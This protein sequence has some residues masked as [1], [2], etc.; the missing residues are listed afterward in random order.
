MNRSVWGLLS[1]VSIVGISLSIGLATRADQQRVTV[2]GTSSLSLQLVSRGWDGTVADGDS[3]N[4]EISADGRFLT[5]ASL[6]TNLTPGDTNQQQ[7]IF[8]YARETEQLMN[9]T[10][11][12]NGASAEPA[13]SA[14][15][16][17]VVF[18]SLATNLV[19][20]D[21]NNVQDVFL[22]DRALDM[23]EL[24]SVATSGATANGPSFYPAVS[25]DGRYVAF[26]SLA[27]N[28]VI[29]DTN[30]FLDIYVRD[31]ELGVT[32]LV[33]LGYDGAP[34]NGGSYYPALSDDGRYVVFY[35]DAGNLVV[36]D[37]PY[38]DVFVYDRQMG[39]MTQVS[40]RAGGGAANG[41]SYLPD[42]AG[43]GRFIAFTSEASNLVVGDMNGSY[44]VFLF[45][46]QTAETT[47]LSQTTTGAPGNGDS[48]VPY[49]SANGRY[50]TYFS[51]ANNLAV[52]DNNGQADAFWL[53]RENGTLWLLSQTDVGAAGNGETTF[54]V[55][56]ADGQTAVFESA[57]TDLTAEATNGQ[58]NI[59][60]AVFELAIAPPPPLLLPVVLFN[61]PPTYVISGQVRDG[62]GR[63]LP[64]VTL[65][66]TDGRITMTDG[67]GRYEFSQL[68]AGVY[69]LTPTKTGYVFTPME[70]VV[71]VPPDTANV[72]FTGNLSAT[73]TAT[74][75][76]TP[77]VTPTDTPPPS[78]TPT[79]TTPPPCNELLVNG[80]FETT[81]GWEIGNTAYPAAYDTAVVRSGSRAMR[82]GII[83]PAHNVQTYSSTSQWV[84]IPANASSATLSFWWYPVSGES[85]WVAP[86][87]WA[88]PPI[89]DE[90]LAD[91]AQFV[92]VYEQNNTQHTLL[93]Q[94]RNDQTWLPSQ[95]DLMPFAGQTIR[96]YFGVF[97]NGY[98]GVT[99]MYV[100]DVSLQVCRP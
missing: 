37:G 58:R 52:N 94:R 31:R 43:D 61:Y 86:Q 23:M 3:Q 53:D 2:A 79:A 11:G 74:P 57:A 66:T 55:V 100:D 93:F 15:G 1:L 78:P 28:L 83:N 21:T 84:T 65:T 64:D 7:D 38:S 41:S 87:N 5:F 72:D 9:V 18:E 30:L 14:D 4:S 34:S 12:A 92:I 99:G 69:Q 13:L 60:L 68:L 85:F 19:A 59:F 95:F 49:L 91:D 62:D 90:P 46:Q 39:A 70:R 32:E 48:L 40:T 73:A 20:E 33:T 81:T 47:L 45:D 25:S 44:D 88:A 26:A 89:P 17:F 63:P 50:L 29:S 76:A 10:V 51:Y 54:T 80:G 67:N 6:A 82:V 16:R 71:T 56:A 77:T 97:N 75:T 22:Y 24:V 36:E 35:S 42:I 98:S 8:V 96:I 27:R